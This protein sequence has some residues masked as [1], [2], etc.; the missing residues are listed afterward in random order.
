MKEGSQRRAQEAAVCGGDPAEHSQGKG[1]EDAA[2]RTMATHRVKHPKAATDSRGRLLADRLHS[3]P[4]G[5]R[6][7]SKRQ[8]DVLPGRGGGGML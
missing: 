2:N 8:A 4:A 1:R 3:G 5:G 7:Q 6:Q